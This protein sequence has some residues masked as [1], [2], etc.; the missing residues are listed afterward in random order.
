LTGFCFDPAST[1]ETPIIWVAHGFYGFHDAPDWSGKITRLSGRNFENVDDAVIHLPRSIR[2]HLTNQPSFGP[3]GALYFPQGSNT[4]FGAPDSDWGHRP[5]RLLSAAILRLDTRR[6][7]PGHPVDARTPD[8]GGNYDSHR[9]D[10]PL[11]I[12]AFGVRLAYD[13]VWASDGNLYVPTNGSAAGGNTPGASSLK[14]I[15]TSEDDW[16][17]R[18]TPGKYYGHPNPQQGRYILN[19]G[20]PTD[21]YDFAEVPQYTVGTLPDPEW[22]P[23]VHVFGKHVS[24]NGIIEYRSTRF[25]GKLHGKLL[26]CR[27]NVPGDITVLEVQPG[28]KI[29]PVATQIAGFG[30]LSNPLDLTE[31]RR[32]GC[33]YVSEYGARRITLLRPYEG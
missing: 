18:I 13:L 16:L 3:D 23:A 1:V 15:S 4:A 21:A 5:E 30:G 19:G 11:T 12:H 28:G 10:A 31:D 27:Y 14:R 2:D 7:T 8:G 29:L 22:D 26:V 24:A 25:G 33:I 9:A 32:T 17:F 6:V 20:N